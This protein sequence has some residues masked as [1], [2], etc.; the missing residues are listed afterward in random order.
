VLHSVQSE[1][2]R[3]RSVLVHRPGT[4]LARLRPPPGPD[5][6]AGEE[7]LFDG[8]PWVARA[9]QEH[10]SFTGVLRAEGVDVLELADV[11]VEVSAVGEARNA[12]VSSVLA[13]P[14]LGEPLRRR[15]AGY[16]SYLDDEGLRDL[17]V[18]GLTQQELRSGSGLVYTLLDPGDFV[19]APLPH[20]VFTRDTGAFLGDSIAVASLSGTRAREPALAE[21]VY[22][23]HPRFLGAPLLHERH[24]EPLAGG[25]VLALG[26]GVVAVATGA[27]TTA[28]AA[29]A[30]SR[31]ALRAGVAHTV[32]VVPLTGRYARAHLDTLCTPVDVD[33]VLMPGHA[34]ADLVAYE[35]TAGPEGEPEIRA[36]RPLLTVAAQALGVER[37]RVIPTAQDPATD[38]RAQFDDGGNTLALAP[39]ICVGYER[40]AETNAELE[41]AGIEVRRCP[42]SELRGSR[43]GPRSLCVPIARDPLP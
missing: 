40:T 19:V 37:L 31:A 28:A 15:L 29:E 36:P 22:R 39:G 16:L 23:W 5:R 12:L 10:D 11:L 7:V 41:R 20:A 3:L 1:V 24:Q 21:A 14:R 25:D 4:E 18:A 9:Q 6:G 33:A 32:L 43:G 8:P 34:A 2:G 13:D 42:G 17:L 30:L 38:G 27:H 35:L 26:P